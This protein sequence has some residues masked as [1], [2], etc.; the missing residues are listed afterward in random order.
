MNR[1]CNPIAPFDAPDPFV[2]YDP[3]TGYY[4]ALFTR[5]DKLEIFRSRRAGSLLTDNDS[6][7]IFTLADGH[8]YTDSIWAPEMHRAPDGRWYVY[9]SGREI[10]DGKDE[11]HLF[12]M[13]ALSDDPFGEWEFKGKPFTAEWGID[14]TMYT[15][16]DGRQYMCFSYITNDETGHHN[17]LQ[18]REMENPWT[19]GER[20]AVIARP[21]LPWEKMPP[22]DKRR[23]INEGPFFVEAGGRL[24]ILYSANAC[25]MVEY[26]LGVLEFTGGDL[27]DSA[28]WVKHPEP[29]FTTGNGVYG[30]GHASFF[31]SPDG[32]ELWIAYHAMDGWNENNNWKPRYMHLQKVHLDENG[33]FTP[34][35][36]VADGEMMDPP[37]GEAE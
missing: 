12:V 26:C 32:S 20:Y 16:P 28:N 36:P 3:V 23:T 33:T 19:F 10:I 6:K 37:A 31:R 24:F 2:T 1:F 29:V 13:G 4:Y 35:H 14:P 18:I 22:F 15:A 5:Q 25:W 7:V 27:C 11:Y 34:A 30:P 21:E 8:G 17:T 9:S